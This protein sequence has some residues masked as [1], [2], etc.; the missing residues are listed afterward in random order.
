[1]LRKFFC[2]ILLLIVSTSTSVS[3]IS[4]SQLVRPVQLLVINDKLN[5]VSPIIQSGISYVP[6][7]AFFEAFGYTILVENG[8]AT[9]NLNGLKYHFSPSKY[10]VEHDQGVYSLDNP[11]MELDGKLYIPLRQAAELLKYE[12]TYD[13]TRNIINLFPFGYGEEEAVKKLMNNL[14][15]SKIS[16]INLEHENHLTT[17]FYT[18]KDEWSFREIP[19]K[20]YNVSIH[21][22]DYSSPNEAYIQASYI[23]KTPVYDEEA[24]CEYWIYKKEGEWKFYSIALNSIQRDVPK[25]IESRAMQIIENQNNEQNQ[26]LEDL[27][28]YYKALNEENVEKTLQYTS[29]SLIN[30]WYGSPKPDART[31][32]LR[33]LYR[34]KDYQY[35][36]SNERVIFLGKQEAV[37]QATLEYT[38]FEFLDGGTY[39]FNALIY[40]DYADGHWTYASDLSLDVDYGEDDI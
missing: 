2:S 8:K 11:I 4:A 27:R 40:M 16:Y 12:I 14:I 35:K 25:D 32:A 26:V 30:G 9:V 17:N 18:Q 21:K 22:I 24:T 13:Q 33:S 7:R 5:G 31:N 39:L 20:E 15:K 37:V 38:G 29:P 3:A 19:L 6:L 10:E 28:E 36:I 34:M 1:M 23:K